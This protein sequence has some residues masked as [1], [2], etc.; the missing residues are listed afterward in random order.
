MFLPEWKASRRWGHFLPPSQRDRALSL[1]ALKCW[2]KKPGEGDPGRE[3][4]RMQRLGAEREQGRLGNK[5]WIQVAGGM[6]QGE[7]V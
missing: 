6:A 7:A 2:L 1:P 4:L 3:K 5:R